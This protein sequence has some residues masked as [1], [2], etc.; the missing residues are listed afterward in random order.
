[1][2]RICFL[3]L[4]GLGLFTQ[5]SGS[6]AAQQVNTA[7]R[8]A[9]MLEEM[10]GVLLAAAGQARANRS[11]FKYRPVKIDLNWPPDPQ[12]P[13]RGP[14]INICYQNCSGDGRPRGQSFA[15]CYAGCQIGANL[16]FTQRAREEARKI[17]AKLRTEFQNASTPI[18]RMAIAQRL[19]LWGCARVRVIGINMC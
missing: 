17:C 7:D 6:L 16:D 5:F 2:T 14:Q 11:N 9:Q 10:A 3:L 15:Q 12:L 18:A 1:M 19:L 4:F 13:P 8:N